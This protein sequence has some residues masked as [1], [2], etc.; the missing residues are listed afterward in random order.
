MG[1]VDHTH[2][3]SAAQSRQG[4]RRQQPLGVCPVVAQAKLFESGEVCARAG[5]WTQ[6]RR[7]EA[8]GLQDSTAFS[9]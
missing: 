3:Q 5:W 4:V 1:K 8:I 7:V 6:Q 2:R 9:F